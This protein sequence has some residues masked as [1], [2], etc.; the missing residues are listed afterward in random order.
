MPKYIRICQIYIITTLPIDKTYI[1]DED[2]YKNR[3]LL[4]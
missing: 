1:R 3:P 2:I 4:P